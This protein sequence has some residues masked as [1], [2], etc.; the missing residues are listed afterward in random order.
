MKID[1]S[2]AITTALLSVLWIILATYLNIPAWAGFLGCTTYFAI[3]D[4][5]WKSLIICAF[6]LASGGLLACIS[7]GITRF[8]AGSLHV[9]FIA[10]G[11]IAFIMCIQARLAYLSFIPAAFI[12]SCTVF[13]GTS[14]LPGASCALFLGLLTGFLMKFSGYKLHELTQ[15]RMK[16]D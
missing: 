8:Y 3:N 14:Q 7:L 9:L 5:S 2:I 4:H 11:F 16:E 1:F 6:S 15:I 10:T 12:G 13:A